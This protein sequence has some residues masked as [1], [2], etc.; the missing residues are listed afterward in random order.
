MR[1]SCT[2]EWLQLA[3]GCCKLV[4]T[5]L[6]LWCVVVHTVCVADV[7]VALKLTAYTVVLTHSEHHCRCNSVLYV[8]HWSVIT[9]RM[10]NLLLQNAQ[11]MIVID[12]YCALSGKPA[13]REGHGMPELQ[14]TEHHRKI[15]SAVATTWRL[16]HYALQKK[17]VC[18]AN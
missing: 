14:R 1:R 16:W 4:H 11:D 6:V 12:H 3:E 18:N 10:L 2:Q 13:S 17:T 15:L 9:I 5:L 7:K 8:P